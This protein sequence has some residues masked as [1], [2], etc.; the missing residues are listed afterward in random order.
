MYT[1]EIKRFLRSKGA[2]GGLV[3][4]LL[5]G[6]LSLLI[7][8]QF[9]AKQKQAQAEI[10]QFQREHIA[11]NVR[12]HPDEMGLLLYYLRFA[13]INPSQ[14][15]N[16]LSI[17]QRDVQNSIQSV[18]I[19]G[20]ENQKYDTDLHNPMN[21]L[22]GNL[23]FSF[24]VIF[25]FPL[26]IIALTYNLLSEEKEEG[27]LRLVATQAGSSLYFLL[28][29][30]SIRVGAVF[31]V[32]LLLFGLALVFLNLPL[33]QATLAFVGVAALYLLFWFAVS[34]W[35]ISWQ[36]SSGMNA[37]SLLGIWL[38]LTLVLPAGLNAYLV[39]RYPVPEA[40]STLI[41]QRE[42][43]HEKW[44]LPKVVT[45]DKFYAHY[46]Q[47]KK[48]PLPDQTFSWLWY[49]AMQQMG[50]DE[51]KQ[52][53]Q[54]LKHKLAQREQASEY[55]A[56]LLPCVHTQL[57]FNHLA[58]ADL[59]QQLQYWEATERFHEKLRLYFYPRIFEDKAIMQEKWTSFQVERFVPKVNIN[60]SKMI[61]PSLLMIFLFGSFG[62]GG[63][64]KHQIT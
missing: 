26:L 3:L 35:V 25:L 64:K 62:V 58:G 29:K 38:L 50:D 2:M 18:T 63:L 44:D 33:N 56:Y 61:F 16:A 4:L 28:R 55:F 11:R 52:S 23:D 10:A 12:Y 7:G 42:G 47:Y 21:L 30:M 41:Q 24:V 32:L 19:R 36:F 17:G 48:Y 54:A 22:M 51:S 43:Y 34:I 15:L 20:L 27:T 59:Q 31:V 60:W 57:T 8:R 5:V 40:L 13:L 37:V 6:C 1:L 14:P 46:P 53:A 45:M 49:Y 9:V 39:N